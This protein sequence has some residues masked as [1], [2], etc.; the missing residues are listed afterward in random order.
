MHIDTNGNRQP[1][2]VNEVDPVHELGLVQELIRLAEEELSRANCV[3]KV[4]KV[5]LKVG[6]LS[7]AS[8]EALRFAFEVVIPATKLTGANLEIIETFPLCHC[9]T[10]QHEEVSDTICFTCPKCG[11]SDITIEGGRDLFLESIDVEE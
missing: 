2:H 11:S 4:T 6:K 7:G 5:S 9:H 10:C 8:P 3:S 1:Q